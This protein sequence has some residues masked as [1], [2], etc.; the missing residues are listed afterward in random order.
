MNTLLHGENASA[1]RTRLLE[2]KDQFS[3]EILTLN[4]KDLTEEMLTQSLESNSLFAQ[5]KLVIIENLASNKSIKKPLQASNATSII[6]FEEKP[7]TSSQTT[8]LQKLLPNLKA[9]EFKIDPVVFKFLDALAPQSQKG[10]LPFWQKY[11][12]AEVPEII[13]VMLARQFRLLILSKSDGAELNSEWQRLSTW[14]KQKLSSQANKFTLE[15]LKTNFSAL[16]ELDYKSK[17]GQLPT[18]LVSS[19]E[20]FL[21]SL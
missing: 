20:L 9:E 6:L 11:R 8:N 17:T 21:L 1:A 18:D 15:S 13:L 10:F 14:Q 3:G 12:R 19:L 16:A 2:L 4:S 7:L 5:E